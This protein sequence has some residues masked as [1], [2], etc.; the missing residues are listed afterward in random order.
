MITREDIIE[1]LQEKYPQ[2]H[3]VPQDVVKNGDV[4]LEGICIRDESKIAPT[5]YTQF[6]IER[7]G[8]NLD[9]AIEIISNII[10]QHQA[11]NIDV[12]K[13]T[14]PTFILE[15]I[16]IGI[17]KES[18]ENLVKKPVPDFEGIEQYLYF[19]ETGPT[20]HDMWSVKLRPELMKTAHI[21]EELAW[22]LAEKHT[23]EATTIKSM[24]EILA[25]MMGV[26]IDSDFP[27]MTHCEMYVMSGKSES[28]STPI[29]SAKISDIDL[30]VVAS[31]VCFSASSHA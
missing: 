13:L 8:D 2:Y 9:E 31:K 11:P 1:R 27:D 22:E 10:E 26:D 24:S 23:F 14:D 16:R 18:D 30:I 3:I 21:S 4:H 19:S 12:D 20:S 5:I 6:I 17:Q 7:C 25:E 28:M 29:I 15:R